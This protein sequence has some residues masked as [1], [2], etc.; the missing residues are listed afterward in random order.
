MFLPTAAA[1]GLTCEQ[2]PNSQSRSRHQ[3]F[4]SFQPHSE[5][6]VEGWVPPSRA[7]TH[8]TRPPPPRASALPEELSHGALVDSHQPPRPS[9]CCLAPAPA[10]PVVCGGSGP[11]P[12][13][14]EI[15]HHSSPYSGSQPEVS[16]ERTQ[17][18]RA[19]LT[20]KAT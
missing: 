10:G 12:A 15:S 19:L 6:G 8:C 3:V 14:P 13:D 1:G 20:L 5:R 4:N 17:A 7:C 16:G 18:P 9:S 2:I 11:S